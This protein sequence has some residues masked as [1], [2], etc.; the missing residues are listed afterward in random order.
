MLTENFTMSSAGLGNLCRLKPL[1]INELPFHPKLPSSTSSEQ[2]SRPSLA[3]FIGQALQEGHN[4]ALGGFDAFKSKSH[5]QSDPSS[6]QVEILSRSISPSTIDQLDGHAEGVQSNDGVSRQWSG[7]GKSPG[8]YWVMRRSRHPNS[9]RKGTASFEEFDKALRQNHSE[10]EM[11]YTPDIYDCPEVLNWDE[12]IKSFEDQ[13]GRAISDTYSDISLTIQEMCHELPFP[14]YNRVFSVVVLTARGPD[15]DSLIVVQLPIDISAL[16]EA[17][18][19]NGTNK[20][21][22]TA[23]KNREPVVA[24]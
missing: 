14:Y 7:A 4:F 2:V 19:S 17:F 11:A 9:R 15:T 13:N 10:N 5:K 18:Y 21:V 12:Q 6:S 3:H 20:T 23:G 22:G 8:E 1:H 24:G 16:P